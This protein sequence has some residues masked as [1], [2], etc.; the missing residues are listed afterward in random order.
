[1]STGLHILVVDDVEA[2][3]TNVSTLLGLSPSVA[4]VQTAVDGLE[5]VAAL[6]DALPDVIL[7][8]I[9]MPRMDGITAARIIRE[10]A[11]NVGIVFHSAY[12]DDALLDRAAA[13]D[14]EAFFVKGSPVRELISC[15]EQAA[16]SA[17][18]RRPAA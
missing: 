2:I 8:D 10:R 9:R 6:E 1:M 11:P 5:A 13:L 17:R 16:C 7:M 15:V 14:A 12:D 3:R 4:R 18:A